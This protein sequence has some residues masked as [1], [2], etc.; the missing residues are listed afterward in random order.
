M[1]YL[2]ILCFFS[3]TTFAQV[4]THAR[5]DSVPPRP[6]MPTAYPRNDFY[7]RPGDNPNVV[8]ATL[9]NMP[10]WGSDTSSVRM[11]TLGD[12]KPRRKRN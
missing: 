6:G 7:R 10:V 2:Y 4:P 1:H 12:Q 8:R 5:R 9:D 3:V 11:P